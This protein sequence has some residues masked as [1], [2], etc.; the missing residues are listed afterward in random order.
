MKEPTI[1]LFPEQKTYKTPNARND[2]I[3]LHEILAKLEVSNTMII[4]NSFSATD[5]DVSN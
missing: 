1:H 2:A 4:E 5:H 3:A